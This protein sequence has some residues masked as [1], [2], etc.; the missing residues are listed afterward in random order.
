MNAAE[1]RDL[2]DTVITIAVWQT[3]VSAFTAAGCPNLAAECQKM[4]AEL[5]ANLMAQEAK[6]ASGAIV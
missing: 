1:L 4:I 6:L 3:R 5:N 2:A